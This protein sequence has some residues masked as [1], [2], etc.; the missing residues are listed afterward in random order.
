MFAAVVA[1]VILLREVLLPFVTGMVLACLLN[2][3][4]NRLERLGMNRL[5]ATLAIFLLVVVA[6]TLLIVLAVPVLIR[7]L[8][9]FIESFPL[10]VGRLHEFPG[11]CKPAG[12][13]L[14]CQPAGS[15]PG[16]RGET[17]AGI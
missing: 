13:T 8:S 17:C 16:A 1:V 3:L 7:E 15:L 5:L 12:V 9:Y 11:V 4:A 6:I 2:P 14:G 10:Y